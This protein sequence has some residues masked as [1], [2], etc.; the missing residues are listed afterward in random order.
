MLKK[1]RLMS[2]LESGIDT[3]LEIFKESTDKRNKKEKTILY[4]KFIL[5]FLLSH[6][7]RSILM[8]KS[9]EVVSKVQSLK[10][11]HLRLRLKVES[12][13]NEGAKEANLFHKEKHIEIENVYLIQEK[14][15]MHEL[16][17]YNKDVSIILKN[18]HGWQLIPKRKV[19][20]KKLSKN[21]EVIL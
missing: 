5:I 17:I 7:I 15:E 13:I 4:I 14:G 6:S 1:G 9:E 19:T 16:D 8:D 3:K 20:K 2:S 21:Y 18:Q 12:F 11:D 10:K